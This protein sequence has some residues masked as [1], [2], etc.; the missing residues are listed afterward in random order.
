MVPRAPGWLPLPTVP[1]PPGWVGVA[2]PPPA[3]LPGGAVAGAAEG[4]AP[5]EE[6]IPGSAQAP[7]ARRA[8][9]AAAA[10]QSGLVAIVT[11]GYPSLW[12]PCEQGETA[13]VP[14]GGDRG[15]PDPA[16]TRRR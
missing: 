8:A 5:E 4:P 11:A 2:V 13:S 15:R 14:R 6:R 3:V 9:A 7:S 12:A 10:R 16:A 1:E